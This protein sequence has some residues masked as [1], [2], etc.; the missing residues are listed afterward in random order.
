MIILLLSI[1]GCSKEESQLNE[2]S[3]TNKYELDFEKMFK[4]LE[5]LQAMESLE[6]ATNKLRINFDLTKAINEDYTYNDN[7]I[8]ENIRYTDFANIEEFKNTFSALFEKLQIL[9]TTWPIL[10]QENQTDLM[11]AYDNYYRGTGGGCIDDYRKCVTR[12]RRTFLYAI[13]AVPLCGPGADFC[14]VLAVGMY[15]S[16]RGDCIEDLNDCVGY[17]MIPE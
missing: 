17:E 7:Y 2:R 13:A 1:V 5:Y 4:S 16:D 15:N 11:I 6:N 3:L 14:F 8:F 9:K 12:A 10:Q